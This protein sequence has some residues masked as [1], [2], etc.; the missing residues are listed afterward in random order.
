MVPTMSDADPNP[1]E[2]RPL[3]RRAR[4]RQET[5]DEILQ[6][7]TDVMTEDGVNALS[8]A[9]IARRLGVQPPSLYKYFDSLLHIYDALFQRGMTALVDGMR[10]SMAEAALGLPALS[11]GLEANGSWCLDNRAIA[12]L[13]FWRP[14]PS[15]EPSPEAFEPSI[16]MV[17]L[18]RVA[19]ADAIA[20]GQIGATN[21]DEVVYLISML[22]N[23]AIT[24]AM[25]NEP[26]L[27]WG[28]GRFTPLFPRL[29]ELLPALYPP[30]K[31][32]PRRA[33]RS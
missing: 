30:T 16:E 26:E 18:Q 25:A 15:F 33:R 10:T 6:I 23:G 2:V 21:V 32:G 19:V 27:Q 29:M 3:D 4:R 9:E 11:A 12:Q 20:A 28:E 13:L 1:P 24:Q 7:A 22:I 31:A 8:I 14:V 5:I 17:E